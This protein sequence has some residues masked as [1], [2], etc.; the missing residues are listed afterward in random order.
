M[1]FWLMTVARNVLSTWPSS[2][3][4]AVVQLI[5]K[6]ETGYW[7]DLPLAMLQFFDCQV[8]SSVLQAPPTRRQMGYTDH[9]ELLGLPC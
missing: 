4:A 8:H 6:R 9:I 3:H 7:L 1:H 2:A 5:I